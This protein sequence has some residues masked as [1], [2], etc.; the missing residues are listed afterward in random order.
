VSITNINKIVLVLSMN[1]T[2]TKKLTSDIVVELISDKGR[3][4]LKSSP[5]AKKGKIL[6]EDKDTISTPSI[7]STT[8]LSH[9]KSENKLRCEKCNKEFRDRFNYDRHLKSA[10][11]IKRINGE[12]TIKIYKCNIVNC[13]Y[14]STTD[15]ANFKRHIKSH[16]GEKS[17]TYQCLA[18]NF[19]LRDQEKVNNHIKTIECKDNVIKK[20]PEATEGGHKYD[21]G[22]WFI[23]PKRFPRSKMGIYIKKLKGKSSIG[24][25]VKGN[26]PKAL[27]AKGEVEAKSEPLEAK[28][29][30]LEA[31]EEVDAKQAEIKEGEAADSIVTYKIKISDYKFYGLLREN[32]KG[33]L[34]D[35]T[36][37]WMKQEGID[38]SNEGYDEENSIEENYIVIYDIISND[39]IRCFKRDY[40]LDVRGIS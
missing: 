16:S 17:Y 38:P 18:C 14:K 28:Q 13:N 21:N 30:S 27:E 3:Y 15:L 8:S 35:N 7:S 29:K 34:V 1:G 26:K 33:K 39:P 40:G 20:F 23:K 36:I 5:T 12:S 25:L 32:E 11:H 9:L 2:R 4:E 37:K 6:S 31:K 10:G 19:F 24:V 22:G